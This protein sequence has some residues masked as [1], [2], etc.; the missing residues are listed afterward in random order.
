MA[1]TQGLKVLN[2]PIDVLAKLPQEQ[3]IAMSQRP[4]GSPDRIPPDYLSTIL[5]AKAQM[6]QEASNRQAMAQPAK[7]SIVEQAMA[8]NA[9]AEAPQMAP[10]DAGVASLPVPDDMYA[11]ADEGY[12]GGGIV[13]FDDGGEVPGFAAGDFI[14]FDDLPVAPR[15]FS[16]SLPSASLLLA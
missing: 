5:S 14:E 13:A 16:I 10:M 9:Q 12:A 15:N 3:L 2:Q 1:I 11:S 8:I 6:I 4:V 7:P